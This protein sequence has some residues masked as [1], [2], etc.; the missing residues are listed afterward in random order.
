MLTNRPTV[1][2]FMT[3]DPVII[4]GGLTLS[5]AFTRMFQINARHLPVYVGGHLV[6]MLLA[7][8]WSA[9]GA[10]AD[11]IK[12]ACGLSGLYDLEPVRLCYLNDVLALTPESARRNS[13]TLLSPTRPT[14]LILTDGGDE[15]PEYHRQTGELAAAWR[16][17]GV[18]IQELDMTGHNHFSI[19]AELESPFSP[20]ARAIQ[21]QMGLV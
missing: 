11:V 10:P 9:F 21:T 13:P 8:D 15:G 6:G 1:R 18:P 19:V 17:R 20:L 2:E 3:P 12:G 4:D 16:A 5:D 7:T 14:P